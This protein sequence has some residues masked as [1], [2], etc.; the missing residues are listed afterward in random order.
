MKYSTIKEILDNLFFSFINDNKNVKKEMFY[1][2]G[3]NLYSLEIYMADKVDELGISSDLAMFKIDEFISENSNTG[4]RFEFIYNYQNKTSHRV[5]VFSKKI[6]E[7]MISPETQEKINIDTMNIKKQKEVE[8]EK[9]K[10]DKLF[11]IIQK[12]EFGI[13]LSDIIQKTRFYK[14]SNERL[15]ALGL[16]LSQNKIHVTIDTSNKKQKRIYQAI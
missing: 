1:Q 13:S 15:E 16:L 5:Y 12:N 10:L 6:E 4:G 3:D 2:S 14:N 11:F 9:S 7:I 8:K